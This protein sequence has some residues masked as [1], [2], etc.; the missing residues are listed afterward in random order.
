MLIIII[1]TLLDDTKL[2]IL[3]GKYQSLISTLILSAPTLKILKLEWWYFIIEISVMKLIH[4]HGYK[5]YNIK[6]W[7]IKSCNYDK[8][9]ESLTNEG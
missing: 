8:K 9:K 1:N 6:S 4:T 5:N 3:V 7:N 2:E